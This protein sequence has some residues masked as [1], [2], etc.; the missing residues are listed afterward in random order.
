LLDPT[1]RNIS[2]EN[3]LFVNKTKREFQE[4]FVLELDPTNTVVSLKQLTNSS[5]QNHL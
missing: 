4:K 1:D 3:K 5:F 2:E